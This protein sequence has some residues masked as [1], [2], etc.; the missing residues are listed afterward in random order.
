LILG[1]TIGLLSLASTAAADPGLWVAKRGSATVY[2]FGTVHALKSGTDWRTAKFTQAFGRSSDLWIEVVNSDDPAVVQPL[3]Q[4]LGVDQAHKLSDLVQPADRAAYATATADLPGGGAMLD[5]FRPWAAAI[6]LT[7]TP[8]LKA[9]YD[10]ASG[11][12]HVLEREA[13]AA[14]KQ[15]HGFE[16][17]GQQ[18]HV[19]ADLSQA[20]QL[21]LLHETLED[22]SDN[23]AKLKEL[24]DAWQRGDADALASQVKEM[25]DDAPSLYK[26]L[27][28]DRNAR[29]ADGI[30]G[31]LEHPGTRFVA[32]GM[33]HLVDPD[34]VLTDLK[35]RGIAVERE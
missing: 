33:L 7:V 34:S 24:V 16:T 30:A 20:D 1:L 2:L 6:F 3:M 29:F 19:L 35:R 14:G 18:F 23:A 8:I 5:P 21:A 26:T 17:L 22:A 32:V 27:L 31:M 4:E 28:V 12:D 15:I 13:K 25:R 9:G 10:P 11:V